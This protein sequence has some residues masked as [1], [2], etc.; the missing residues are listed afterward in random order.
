[1]QDGAH[2]RPLG[3]RGIPAKLHFLGRE[4]NHGSSSDIG[5]EGAVLNVN[6]T[7]N[8]FTRLALALDRPTTLGKIHGGL[9]FTYCACIPSG[10]MGWRYSARNLK[11]PDKVIKP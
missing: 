4:G 2:D 7:P 5:V 8:N 10:K 6:S 3:C 1:M 11:H 9:A